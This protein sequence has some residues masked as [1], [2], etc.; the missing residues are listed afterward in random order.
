M[1]SDG[2]RIWNW[3]LK[4]DTVLQFADFYEV[5]QATRYLY[6][7]K[8]YVDV[9]ASGKVV[10]RTPTEENKY[11][12]K[13]ANLYNGEIKTL[14]TGRQYH[15]LYKSKDQII[16]DGSNGNYL[17]LLNNQPI[18]LPLWTNDINLI[19][20]ARKGTL[21][22]VIRKSRKEFIWW[23]WEQDKVIFAKSPKV[24][25]YCMAIDKRDSLIA[26]S[27]KDQVWV[28]DAKTGK[29]KAII[30]IIAANSERVIMKF[31]EDSRFLF[32]NSPYEGRIVFG[33]WTE[34]FCL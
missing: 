34:L 9:L 16:V 26:L 30:P 1:L 8:N 17:D 24:S 12:Y 10:F 33:I 32:I 2:Y 4:K 23:D 20:P 22:A 28:L 11:T 18:K 15:R 25:F 7:S 19:Y 27:E 31:S 14:E 6:D 3:D 5:N 29:E 21:W 13:I